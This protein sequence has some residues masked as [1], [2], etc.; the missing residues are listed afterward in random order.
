[1][2]LSGGKIMPGIKKLVGELLF[3]TNQQ[4]F[5]R[6]KI[7]VPVGWQIYASMEKLAGELFFPTNQHLFL[8]P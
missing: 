5:L 8:R 6:K 7:Y 1:M 3:L 2:F 4:L